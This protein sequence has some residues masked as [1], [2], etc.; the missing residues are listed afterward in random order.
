MARNKGKKKCQYI[1]QHLTVV[2][3]FLAKEEIKELFI[4]NHNNTMDFNFL[5]IINVISILLIKR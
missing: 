3:E 1:S 5:C 2:S 4:L